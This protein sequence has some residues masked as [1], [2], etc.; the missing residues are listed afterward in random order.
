MVSAHTDVITRMNPRAA[1]PYQYRP[2]ING[3]PGKPL[4]TEP[5]AFTVPTVPAGATSLFMR[6]LLSPLFSYAASF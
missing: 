5:L 1:L 4:D 2:G 3:L 6:H